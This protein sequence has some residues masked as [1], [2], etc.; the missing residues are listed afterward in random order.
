LADYS[1]K[2]ADFDVKMVDFGVKMVNFEVKMFDFGVKMTKVNDCISLDSHPTLHFSPLKMTART[3][4][5]HPTH[6]HPATATLSA[7]A[8]HFK[9]ANF[10]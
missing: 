1:V 8:T 7:T 6:C 9:S 10:F 5:V 3:Q 4:P 2:T